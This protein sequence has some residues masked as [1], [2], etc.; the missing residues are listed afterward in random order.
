M[1]GI[2]RPCILVCNTRWGYVM[3]PIEC[4][5]IA[6]AKRIGNSMDMAYRVLD[7]KGNLICRG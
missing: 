6:E 3:T 4:K 1:R 7:T 2:K 5:S